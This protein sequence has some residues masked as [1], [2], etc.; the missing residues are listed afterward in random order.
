VVVQNNQL[1]QVIQEITDLETQAEELQVVQ[2]TLPVA[3]EV[4]AQL[5][6]I[7]LLLIQEVILVPVVKVV[8]V[9]LIQS[10]TVQ[11]Q[12]TMLVVAVAAHSFLQKFQEVKAA[13]VLA[14]HQ[15]IQIQ[16][17]LQYMAE[18]TARLTEA[19][20]EE[21]LVMVVLNQL[22]VLAVKVLLLSDGL[23]HIITHYKYY[24]IL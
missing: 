14:E 9:E 5:V 19:V 22:L 24:E 7:Q 6:K 16:T 13:E 17:L 1:N 4:L 20:A 10:Q 15:A 23:N 11:L 2:H 12:F 18:K 21:V 8:M 3:E